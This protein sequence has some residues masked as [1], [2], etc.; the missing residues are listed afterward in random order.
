MESGSAHVWAIAASWVVS[1]T[2]RPVFLS[3]DRTR[4]HAL[5]DMR[6]RKRYL[7]LNVC[8]RR[9]G[10][11]VPFLQFN[12]DQGQNMV[13]LPNNRDWEKERWTPCMATGRKTNFSHY[14]QGGRGYLPRVIIFF[15]SFPTFFDP[16]PDVPYHWFSYY[17]SVRRVRDR[18]KG[19]G[20]PWIAGWPRSDT[21]I[22]WPSPSPSSYGI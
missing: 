18:P 2:T 4:T 16:W 10:R 21:L 12:A 14:C 17:G 9:L 8:D 5:R 20:Q 22:R 11:L 3:L 1:R 13:S 15:F 7:N 6:K 19:H